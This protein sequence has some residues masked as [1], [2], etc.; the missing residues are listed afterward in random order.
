MKKN[1]LTYIGAALFLS[2]ILLT[3]CQGKEQSTEKSEIP[4]EIRVS[5]NE[6][7]FDL[8]DGVKDSILKE[9]PSINRY[10]AEEG[11]A[12]LAFV[13]ARE[14]VEPEQIIPGE[15]LGDLGIYL[16][17]KGGIGSEFIYTVPGYP[18]LVNAAESV[19]GKI[20]AVPLN[21]KLENDLEAIESKVN[22]KTQAVFLINPHNPSGTVSETRAFHDFISRIAK[23]TLVIVDEAYLEYADHF[24]ERTALNNLKA[25]ENVML[26]RT[27]A[28]AYGLGG[29]DIGYAIAPKELAIY[30]K[31]KGVGDTHALNRL[32]IAAA[33]AVLND[34][35]NIAKVNRIVAEERAKWLAFLDKHQLEHTDS[36]ANFIF[37]DTKHPAVEIK[38]KLKEKG[39]LIGPLY[40]EY[41]TWVRISIGLPNENEKIRQELVELLK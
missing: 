18:A 36:Q 20:I 39:I 26:F 25:G 37:F 12:F 34:Q 9:L 8:P 23:K 17:Q 14:G 15:I 16:A 27:L 3:S 22:E 33:K 4:G 38:Q 28:K 13:A 10:A 11:E 31:K 35:A 24:S 19:G 41:S 7:P 5:L 30:L 6:N 40:P 32:S 21:K 2:S 1:H 29:L